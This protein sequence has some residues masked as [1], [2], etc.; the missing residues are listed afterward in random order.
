M[1][2]N[3]QYIPSD[4]L[5]ELQS[6][7]EKLHRKEMKLLAKQGKLQ[8]QIKAAGGC[9]GNCHWYSN[10]KERCYRTTNASNTLV[11]EWRLASEFCDNW[12]LA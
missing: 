11:S 8:F 7:M 4:E 5:Q 1:I 6:K 2:D 12:S 9:C 10:D 3:P